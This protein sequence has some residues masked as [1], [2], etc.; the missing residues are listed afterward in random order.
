MIGAPSPR[1]TASM[2]E[3]KVDPLGTAQDAPPHGATPVPPPEPDPTTSE[4]ATAAEAPS[5]AFTEAIADVSPELLAPLADVF[6]RVAESR[7][8][9]GLGTG[10][11]TF[12][13]DGGL[14]SPGS[15]RATVL[16]Q[17]EGAGAWLRAAADAEEQTAGGRGVDARA[18]DAWLSGV[19]DAIGELLGESLSVEAVHA[20]D[21]PEDT[22]TIEGTS[23]LPFEY[24]FGRRRG[25]AWLWMEP[26]LLAQCL[27][28]L[29]LSVPAEG[30]GPGSA[31][32]ARLDTGPTTPSYESFPLLSEQPQGRAPSGIDVL[33]DV[34]LEVS[35]EL[36]RTE[37]QIREILSLVPGSVLE[38]DRVAGDPIDVLIN[39]RRIARA[40][41]VVVDERFAI[42]ITDI[43]SPEERVERLG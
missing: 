13:E 36:G 15:Q 7:W 14:P 35:V 28:E 42:R 12:A 22:A 3:G 8:A 23:V 4:G 19:G 40:E 5:A 38:L 41:V 43:L 18:L 31:G 33:L 34:P 32:E 30:V 29:A 16:V 10:S 37:R 2:A 21:R 25:R 24:Q 9:K 20:G 26:G 6:A 27:A 39:G 11:M 1:A 17:R